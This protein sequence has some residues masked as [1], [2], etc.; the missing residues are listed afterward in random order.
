MHTIAVVNQKGG[1]GK[2]TI[3][4]NLADA[5][6]ARAPVF[7]ID[8]DPQGSATHWASLRETE[9]QEEDNLQVIAA[10]RP[11]DARSFRALRDR[12][13]RQAEDALIVI[14][15]PPSVQDPASRIALRLADLA[16]IPV[17]PS[18]LDVWAAEAAVALARDTQNK[19]GNSLPKIALVP[20]QLR[21]TTI[22]RELPATLKEFRVTIA[23][24][25]SLRVAV[26]E[27]AT[28]GWT[29]A[30]YAPGHPSDYEFRKLARFVRRQL[31]S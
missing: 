2:T 5:L 7:I 28:D 20:N 18:P 30:E 9:D 11:I 1:V 23:P 21:L 26:S 19:R 3:T 13:G 17:L 29:V 27:S 10:E 6:S 22:S 24:G 31:S 16:L 15:C 12:L 4:M 25:I 14:D 8:A